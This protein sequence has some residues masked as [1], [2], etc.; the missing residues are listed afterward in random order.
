MGPTQE[1]EC[2]R[3][4]SRG[5]PLRDTEVAVRGED[6]VKDP[7]S[8]GLPRS[9]AQ[10]GLTVSQQRWVRKLRENVT[11]AVLP[12]RCPHPQAAGGTATGSCRPAREEGPALEKLPDSK[13]NHPP[14]LGAASGHCP[15][16]G[17]SELGLPRGPLLPIPS[18]LSSPIRSASLARTPASP[19]PEFQQG[20]VG[21]SA[22]LGQEGLPHFPWR[23]AGRS[24]TWRIGD[25]ATCM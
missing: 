18:A 11:L 19:G 20:R 2:G 10:E 17:L 21:P 14:L 5:A 13:E 16:L 4:S 12:N 24:Q 6:M 22:T 3:E 1:L 25:R 23:G 9:P 7:G 8:R 15:L